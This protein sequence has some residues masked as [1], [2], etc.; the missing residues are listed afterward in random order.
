MCELLA[1]KLI[2][3]FSGDG[4]ELVTALTVPFS[5]FVGLEDTPAYQEQ[6]RQMQQQEE[7]E[8][9]DG[10]KNKNRLKAALKDMAQA[11][12][13]ALS[14]DSNAADSGFG[15]SNRDAALVS[16]SALELALVSSSKKFVK[17]PLVQRVV[18]GIWDGSITIS[19]PSQNAILNDD[20]KKKPLNFYDPK[21]APL[22]DHYRLRVP[23]IRSALEFGNFILVLGF[24][25]MCL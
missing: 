9:A 14:G 8:E 15:G 17:S 7:D 2:R 16:S 24:Y 13:F 23:K 19:N 3:T 21:T 4:L 11:S 6:Q 20:Y 22:L 5:P 12:G 10:S 25:I 18:Q 1:L